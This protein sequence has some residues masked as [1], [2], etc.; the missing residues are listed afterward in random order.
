MHEREYRACRR[1]AEMFGGTMSKWGRHALVSTLRPDHFVLEPSDEINE[2]QAASPAS[3][4]DVDRPE[5]AIP[6]ANAE[7]VSQETVSNE[8]APSPGMEE[9]RESVPESIATPEPELKNW[10]FKRHPKCENGRC[11]RL[12]CP[13]C[14]L[15]RS[16]IR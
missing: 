5:V 3:D 8:G 2:P 12:R 15:C 14:A 7:S 11:E 9:L 13:C 6:E 4:A 1:A 16:V 10:H